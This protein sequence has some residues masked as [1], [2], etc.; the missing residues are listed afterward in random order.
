M[1]SGA[2]CAGKV[3][4]REAADVLGLVWCL[5]LVIVGT[6]PWSGTRVALCMLQY[7]TFIYCW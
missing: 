6:R 3:P 7:G 5:S 2:A 1:A 4:S